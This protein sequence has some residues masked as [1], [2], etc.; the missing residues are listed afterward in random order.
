MLVIAGESLIDLVAGRRADD[1]AWPMAAHPGGSPFNCAIALGRLGADVGF[2]GP[3][4]TDGFGDVLDAA[5]GASGV[6]RLIANRSEAPTTLAVVSLNAEGDARYRFYREGTADT[7]FTMDGLLGALPGKIGLFHCGG[8]CAVRER[9]AGIW[10]AVAAEAAR[11]GAVISIDPN[12]RPALVD[13]IGAYRTRLD[14]FFKVAH[15][16]RMSEEDLKVIEAGLT[17]ADH[18]RRFMSNS[19]CQLVVITL[20]ERGS[21]GFTRSGEARAESWRAPEFV[22]TV[23]AGDAMT[24]G[25]IAAIAERGAL[26]PAAIGAL[27]KDALSDIL[28]FGA[29][30]AGLTCARAGAHSPERA[31]V[32][33]ARA[34]R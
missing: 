3:I 2:L 6:R 21:W 28:Q 19:A 12:P 15:V 10:L 24:A 22:D 5:L 18:A 4:S 1:G 8:F 26:T 32:D 9:D 30:V 14:A 27:G 23:G 29:V 31:E 20:G 11:R 25:L 13:D 17:V 16:I 33:A 7:D 34:G